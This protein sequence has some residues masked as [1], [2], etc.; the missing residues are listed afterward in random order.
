MGVPVRRQPRARAL[1]RQC[2]AL[3]GPLLIAFVKQRQVEQPFAGVVDDIERERAVCA[4]LPLVVDD[5]PQFADVDRRVRPAALLDQ[6]ADVVL[7]IEPWHRVV[8]LRLQPGAGDPPGRVWLENRKA[9]AAGE[10]VDQRRDEDGLAG[11]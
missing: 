11:A 2:E 3:G 7:I 8:G 5:Q 4:I 9:A 6:G 1:A 10:A